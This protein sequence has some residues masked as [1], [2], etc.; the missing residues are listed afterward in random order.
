MRVTCRQSPN[1]AIPHLHVQFVEGV[2]EVS[3]EVAAALAAYAVHG[4]EA[5]QV[6]A[7]KAAAPRRRS[8]KDD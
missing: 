6:E 4:V 2:A 7:P 8:R 3:E 5:E 1:L